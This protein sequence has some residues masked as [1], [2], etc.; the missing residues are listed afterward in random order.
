MMDPI[1]Q[2]VAEIAAGRPVV[3]VDDEDRENEGDLIFAAQM[4]TQQ[5]L[6]FMVRHTS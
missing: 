1:E 6:A 4:A 3:V 5:L 2:A